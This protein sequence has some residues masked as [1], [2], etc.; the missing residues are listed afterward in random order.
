M[1]AVKTYLNFH[2]GIRDLCTIS[3][4]IDDIMRQPDGSL[5]RTHES[6]TVQVLKHIEKNPPS[7]R[8]SNPNDHALNITK[9]GVSYKLNGQLSFGWSIDTRTNNVSYPFRISFTSNHKGLMKSNEMK[10]AQELRFSIYESKQHKT[11]HSR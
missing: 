8:R 2:S 7:F 5:P 3:P 1:N 4:L 11:H 9:N 10:K 6:A